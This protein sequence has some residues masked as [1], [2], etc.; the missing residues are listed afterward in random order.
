MV[1]EAPG[2]T[3][4]VPLPSSVPLPVVNVFVAVTLPVSVPASS[5]SCG[6][7]G[8]TVPK[9]TV[10]PAMRQSPAPVTEPADQVRVPPPIETDVPAARV[11]L[12]ASLPPVVL[13]A[14]KLTSPAWTSTVPPA[15][16]SNPVVTATESV[17]V[18]RR[19]VPALVNF[20]VV[21][22]QLSMP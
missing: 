17:P 19:N 2:A 16:L 21:E 14:E 4:V 1:A 7:D 11:Q 6:I 20:D 18:E 13:P 10:P 3:V 12:P 22:P 9:S 15:R 5:T 8:L